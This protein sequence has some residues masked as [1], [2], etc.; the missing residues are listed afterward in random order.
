MC[1]IHAY[2]KNYEWETLVCFPLYGSYGPRK[3]SGSVPETSASCICEAKCMLAVCTDVLCTPTHV[4][5]D[6]E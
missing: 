1:F 2:V 3:I 5:I 4:V 6:R